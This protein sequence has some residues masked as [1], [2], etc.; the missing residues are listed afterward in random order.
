MNRAP[1]RQLTLTIPTGGLLVEK[2]L[3]FFVSHWTSVF[4]SLIA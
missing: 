2:G 3:E 4:L 1:M